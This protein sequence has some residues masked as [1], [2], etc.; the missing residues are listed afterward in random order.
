MAGGVAD[1]EKDRFVF[2]LGALKCFFTPWKPVHGITGV[3]DQVGAFLSCQII[4]LM[5]RFHNIVSSYRI[6]K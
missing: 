6:A 4:G 3:L 1:G 2:R 5:F